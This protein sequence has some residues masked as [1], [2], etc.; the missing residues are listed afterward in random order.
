MKAKIPC[1]LTKKQE[2]AMIEEIDRQIAE[3]NAK[4]DNGFDAAVLWV[5]HICFGFG[6]KRLRKFYD[7]FR[8][9]VMNSDKWMYGRTEIEMLK[10]IGVDIEA[11]NKQ[12]EE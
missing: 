8:A 4:N 3:Q 6:E 10:G 11:W 7:M 9:T 12:Q 1:K 2:K 5:L